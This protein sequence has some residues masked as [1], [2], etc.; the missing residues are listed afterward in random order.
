MVTKKIHWLILIAI[1]MFGFLIRYIGLTSNP[2]AL[3]WDEVSHAYNAYSL[4]LTGKDQWSQAFPILNFRAYGD[5]PTTLNLY[6]TVPFIFILGPNDLAARLPHAFIGTLIIIIG[7]ILGYRILNNRKLA[8]LTAFLFAFSPWTLFTSRQVLQSNWAILISCLGLTLLL[9]KKYFLSILIFFISL[10]SYH[11]TRIFIPLLLLLLLF[12]KPTKFPNTVKIGFILIIV[13]AGSILWFSQSR[14]RSNWISILDQGAVAHLEEKRNQSLLNPNLTR[15]IYNRPVYF[16]V[17]FIKNYLGYFSPQYLF[18]NGGTQYQYSLPGFGLLNPVFLPFFYFG[19][20]LLFRKKQW[21]I[22][23]WLLLSP[24]PAAITRD[25]FAVLRSGLMI[26]VVYVA[27][28]AGLIYLKKWLF[29][30]PI[31]LIFLYFAYTYAYTYIYKYPVTFAASWQAGY[32][33]MVSTVK[34]NYSNYDQ[35]IITKKF[36]EPHEYIL[37]YWPYS[38]AKYQ[39]ESVLW[40]FHANWYWVD[41]FDKFRF[42]NDWEIKNYVKNLPPDNKY[43]VIDSI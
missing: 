37:W 4:L 32:T 41:G 3:N 24:I 36:G 21:L 31:I 23:A 2:P 18:F 30:I 28:A 5:Y 25:Q 33:Q 19:L 8:L 17:T 35:F 43:L 38:P 14:A 42:V 27:I 12:L 15:L 13:F 7:Y 22:I 26:P 39:S 1:V 10:F 11:N 9:S 29:T 34:Q 40:D 20:Y 16:T 6:M